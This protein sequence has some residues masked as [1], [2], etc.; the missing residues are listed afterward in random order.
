MADRYPQKKSSEPEKLDFLGDVSMKKQSSELSMKRQFS[1]PEVVYASDDHT[2]VLKGNDHISYFGDVRTGK[3][4]K[5]PV[6]G[7]FV[8]DGKIHQGTE[9][10]NSYGNAAVIFD[11]SGSDGDNCEFYVEEDYKG[12]EF[13]LKFSSPGGNS[14]SI[15]LDNLNAWSSERRS[16]E[17]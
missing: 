16:D 6:G 8:G 10:M 17:V 13:S 1:K 9:G 11:D 7:S 4:S 2:D 12:Q 5:S 14:S 3:Q 15:P